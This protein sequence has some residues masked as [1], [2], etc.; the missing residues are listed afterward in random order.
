MGAAKG[1][2]GPG[3]QRETFPGARKSSPQEMD[4]PRSTSTPQDSLG[5]CNLY[6][7]IPL[8]LP[9]NIL[10]N[11]GLGNQGSYQALR[12]QGWILGKLTDI[13]GAGLLLKGMEWCH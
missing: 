8:A 3:H 7:E 6:L 4:A 12:H 9:G 13:K 2:E 5:P 1:R 10:G 11:L